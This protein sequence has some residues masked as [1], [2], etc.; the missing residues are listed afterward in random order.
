MVAKTVTFTV[1]DAWQ[2]PA[3]YDDAGTKATEQAL[4]IGAQILPL[5][6]RECLEME[7]RLDEA[8]QTGVDEAVRSIRGEALSRA[9]AE[10]C[11]VRG[12]LSEKMR[13][14]E[15]M[16]AQLILLREQLLV[17]A[18]VAHERGVNSE[19]AASEMRTQ[20]AVEE[21]EA[22]SDVVIKLH[23]ERADEAVA[24]RDALQCVVEASSAEVTR[25]RDENASLKTPSGIGRAG[26]NTV[27]ECLEAAGYR[28]YDT[29]K[30]P[31]RDKY[32]DLLVVAPDARSES[33]SSGDDG[34]DVPPSKGMRLAIEVKNRG[35]VCKNQLEAFNKRV[36]EGL[37]AGRFDGAMFI[38]IRSWI[39]A[40]QAPVRIVTAEDRAGRSLAPVAYLGA[41]RAQ[42]VEPVASS[43][44]ELQTHALFDLLRN[45]Q[46]MRAQAVGDE[47]ALMVKDAAQIRQLFDASSSA[48]AELFLEFSRHHT[49]I[50]SLRKSL[51]SMRV[52]AL[53][54]HRRLGRVNANVPWLQCKT[55]LPWEKYYEH[56]LRLAGEHR[57][58]WSN[59]SGRDTLDGAIGRGGVMAAIKTELEEASAVDTDGDAGSVSAGGDDADQKRQRRG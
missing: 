41:V 34:E 6:T 53:L 21:A 52:K 58:V 12:E 3:W 59:V 42:L 49:L 32:L 25:L 18:E 47:S 23:K 36:T 57:L 45:A 39:P 24:Q 20:R 30:P 14:S 2:K 9:E 55:S 54:Q 46:K 15:E 7:R 19:R 16:R 56:A 29:S 8:R 26:E 22:R 33:E 40:Q 35:S 38:S 37:R 17:Q 27:A 4:N 28:V 13:E 44:I 1:G 10:M 51:E 5:A 11:A 43:N 48:T 50:E 31:Y